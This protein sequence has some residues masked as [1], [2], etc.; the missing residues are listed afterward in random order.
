[1][2]SETLEGKKINN[3]LVSRHSSTLVRYSVNRPVLE[4]SPTRKSVSQLCVVTSLSVTGPA[5]KI[6]KHVKVRE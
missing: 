2:I 5:R 1:M 3:L 6:P 4:I